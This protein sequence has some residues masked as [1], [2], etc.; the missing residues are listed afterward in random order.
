MG[1]FEGDVRYDRRVAPSFLEHFLAGG[2]A[3]SLVEY[4]KHARY[5]VDLQMRHNPKTNADHASLY[6][7]LT[8][9]LNV[10][11]KGTGLSI[12]AHDTWRQGP[13]GFGG[14]WHLVASTRTWEARWRKVED[15]LERVIPSAA[16]KHAS[17]EGSV[18]AATS[19]FATEDR[20]VLDREVTPHFRNT[21]V[22]SRVL[23]AC[24]RRLLEALARRP[25]VPGKIPQSFGAECDLLALDASGRLLA[26]EVKPSTGSSIAWSPAQATMYARVLEAWVADD[27]D[28]SPGWRAVIQGMYEQRRR[29][30]LIPELALRLPDKPRVVPVVALQRGVTP[31]HID[32]LWAIQRALLA[33]GEGDPE[34]TVYEVS[35]SGRLDALNSPPM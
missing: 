31:V 18:Q 8:S 16:E 5:P 12:E 20:V 22:K 11:A 17:K 33:E 1:N 30:G 7:G 29:L 19:S 3:A 21:A 32:R 2:V 25:P 6:V 14:E 23:D 9:V 34:L 26:V 13:Y 4:A 27:S 24:R 35:L 28:A 10:Y 15:Y